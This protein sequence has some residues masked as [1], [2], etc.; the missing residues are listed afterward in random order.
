MNKTFNINL[1]GMPFVIDDVAFTRLDNY[2]HQ[3]K[4]HFSKS[5][6]S[7]EILQDIEYRIAEIFREKLKT[8]SIVNMNMVEDSIKLMGTPYDISGEPD[9]YS[10][11]NDHTYQRMNKKLFRDLEDKKVAGVCS[12]LAHYF[13]I[14]DPVWIR[15]IFLF[16]L[17]AGGSTVIAYFILWVLVKPAETASDK[18]RMHGEPATI[19]NI[20]EKVEEKFQHFTNKFEEMI[21]KSYQKTK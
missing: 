5:E 4:L 10:R 12:G 13:G 19:N 11:V 9:S 14:E 21:H 15:A 7:K 17:L 18:L 16:G 1:G 20:A 6:S 8:S 2:L 3:L